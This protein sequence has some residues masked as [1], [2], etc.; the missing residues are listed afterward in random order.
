MKTVVP[1]VTIFFA[2][3]IML[4]FANHFLPQNYVLLSVMGSWWF[5]LTASALAWTVIIW[6]TQPVADYLKFKLIKGVKLIVAYLLANFVAIWG[7]ARI[8][9]GFGVRSLVW[10]LLLAAV[11]NTIQLLFWM[12]LAKLKLAEEM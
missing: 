10:V 2:N 12:F 1:F 3:L 8:G 6:F 5:S 11:A 7:I 4:W 9:L